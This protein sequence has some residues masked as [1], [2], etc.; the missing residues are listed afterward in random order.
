[1]MGSLILYNYFLYKLYIYDSA[2]KLQIIKDLKDIINMRL[3]IQAILIIKFI[4]SVLMRNLV[5]EDNVLV[6]Y[7]LKIKLSSLYII[8]N[9]RI[10]NE[11]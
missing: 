5:K 2:V 9:S 4:V 1:M 3:V 8:F 10:Y 7:L 11:R 6:L